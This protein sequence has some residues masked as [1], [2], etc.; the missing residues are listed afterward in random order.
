ML[1]AFIIF[2]IT[3]VL[4]LIKPNYMG[5]SA[6]FMAV[7][8]FL[9]NVVSVKDIIEVIKIVWDPT[10][11]FVGIII[12][13]LILEEIGFFNWAAIKIAKLSR[14]NGYFM[15]I[16]SLILGSLIAAFFTN[17]SAVLILTPIL[18]SQMKILKLNLKTMIAFLF[19][20]G[21]I[22]N[23]ASIPFVFSN[24]TN[25]LTADYFDVRFIKYFGE[26]FLP[27]VGSVIISTSVLFLLFRK[28][29]PQ[30][31]DPNL[32]PEAQSAIKDKKLFVFSWFFL[33][34]LFLGYVVGDLYHIPVSIFAFGGSFVFLLIS[35]FS[36]AVSFRI[37][38][39]APWQILWFSVGLYVVVFGIKDTSFSCYLHSL[40]KNAN[41]LEVGILSSVLSAVFNNL[42]TVMIMDIALK[43]VENQ[44]LVYANIIGVDIGSKITP[45]GSLS[46]LLWFSI[47]QKNGIK[48]G[49]FQ[50]MKYSLIVTPVVLLGVLLMLR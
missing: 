41:I 28:N 46:T 15:F 20:G 19:A 44:L 4:I 11:A 30:K 33:V 37:L 43:G 36:K 23:S 13:S 47:L 42:P 21:F 6:V 2:L 34:L 35:F 18:I 8:A 45:I 22:A 49:F 38:K 29:I 9:L 12:F 1:L 14:G 17:D 39:T 5:Y 10:L 24:L 48:I 50:Y 31:I 40:V 3:L 25:I 7:V 16:Y 26:M 27:F 32:L